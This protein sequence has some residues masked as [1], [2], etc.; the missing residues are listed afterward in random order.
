[1][2]LAEMRAKLLADRAVSND[3]AAMAGVR[4]G[5]LTRHAVQLVG[6]H[7]V[8]T[9]SRV[10]NLAKGYFVGAITETQHTVAK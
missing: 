4:G 10:W 2:S 8:N 7:V 9:G 6:T 1:M 3:N 5:Q